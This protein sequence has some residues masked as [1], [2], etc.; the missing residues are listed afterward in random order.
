VVNKYTGYTGEQLNSF[1]E[2]NRPDWEWLRKNK[3]EE[4][5]LY[6]I[7]KQLKKQKK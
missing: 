2:Q 5:L 1:M 6:Y 4:D 3:K 7:N